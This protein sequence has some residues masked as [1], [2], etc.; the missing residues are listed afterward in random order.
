MKLRST[1][2]TCAAVL[3]LSGSA[4]A[5][6]ASGMYIGLG[7]GWDSLGSL[8]YDYATSSAKIKSD[9][10]AILNVNSGYRF[11][12]GFRLEAEFNY[13][14]HDLKDGYSGDA[15]V[16]GGDVNAFY[17]YTV[18]PRWT[19]SAGGGIGYGHANIKATGD[20][21]PGYTYANG[22]AVYD[23]VTGG[24]YGFQWQLIA[25]TAYAIS[26]QVEVYADYRY[27]S[28]GVD[29]TNY[30]YTYYSTNTSTLY[31]GYAKAKD[32]TDNA[33]M[34]GLRFFFGGTAA[35]APEERKAAPPPPPPAPVAPPPPPVKT[36][37]VFFDFAKSD[38]TDKAQEVVAEAVKTA[39]TNGFVKVK[40]V[41][42]TD[43]V[44]SAKYN[45]ALS[46][47]RANAVKSEFVK[48]GVG[49][50][51]ISVEGHSFNDLLVKTGKNV[52]EPQNRRAQIDLD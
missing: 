44:G 36:Y 14:H 26:D 48:L 29:D 39:K 15:V 9:A 22:N 17:D 1:L 16:K 19:V 47:R 51:G 42:H 33:V 52:K 45:Q 37:I 6:G 41:G 20:V 4:F 27:R 11:D 2:L 49:A 34:V 8:K 30:R 24:K 23:R 12:N 40:I 25:Q 32:V 50:D 46:E 7:A 5:D 28:L 3:A 43:T 13:T 38:L 10:G 35:P 31:Q 21:V 18:L